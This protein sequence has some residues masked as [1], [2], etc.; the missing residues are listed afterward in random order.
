MAPVV[1]D[2][3]SVHEFADEAAFEDWLARHH[4]QRSEVWVK[5]HKLGS[6]LPS[7]TPK[8]AIDVVLNPRF[9]VLDPASKT[10]IDGQS[11]SLSL[12]AAAS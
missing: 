8:Q 2:P 9:G 11:A 4:D 1:V 7:V 12:P 6:G 5:L 3:H 10:I